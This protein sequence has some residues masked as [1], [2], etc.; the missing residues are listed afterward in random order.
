MSN[1]RQW[2]TKFNANNE[3]FHRLLKR[4]GCTSMSKRKA[5]MKKAASLP[6]RLP[7]SPRISKAQEQGRGN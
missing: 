3:A 7:P 1:S 2:T 4:G 5:A 6:N